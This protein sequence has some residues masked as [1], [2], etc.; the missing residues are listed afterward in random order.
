MKEKIREGLRIFSLI[1]ANHQH[2]HIQIL[3]KKEKLA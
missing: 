1:I 3:I 2:R